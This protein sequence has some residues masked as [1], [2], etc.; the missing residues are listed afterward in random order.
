MSATDGTSTQSGGARI[1]LTAPLTE[2]IDHAGYFIQMSMASLPMWL[3]GII[4]R[5]YPH[6]RELEYNADGTARYMPAGVR[7]LE[8]SLLRR[9]PA[10]DMRLLLSRRP[11]PVH[12][13]RHA[14]RRGLHAQSA[15]R[16]LRGRRLHSIFGSSSQPI[17]S[18]YARELFLPDQAQSAPRA[19]PG[20]RRR[21]GRLADHPDQLVRGSRRRLRRRGPQRIGGHARPL[22]AGA[23]RRTA[24][25]AGRRAAPEEPR[26]DPVS[27]QAHHLRRRRDDDRLRPALPVLRARP[28]PADRSA[29]GQ[30]HGRPCAPTSATATSRFRWP[31]RTCSSGA[32]STPPT[33][34]Y[35][36]N[37]EALLDLY[38][39]DRRHARRRAARAEPL[40]DCAGGRRSGADRTALREDHRQEPDPPPAA[41]HAPEEEGAGAADRPRNRVDPHGQA[42]HAEQGRAVPDRRVAERGRSAASRS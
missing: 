8:A 19:L 7:V 40:D 37:R 39:V 3:E 24:A 9:F 18:H 14:G 42:D 11:R 1:V 30:D 36:P 17:N 13:P 10:A 5:K 33:P 15:R 28:Q 34:F 31:P 16:D 21:V 35:F 27:R 26:R 25:A 2:T 38:C 29:Q 20:H 41:Q 12:R 32:R 22:R 23:A 6:W 4:N